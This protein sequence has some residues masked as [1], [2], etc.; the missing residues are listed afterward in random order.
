MISSLRAH[1]ALLPRKGKSDSLNPRQVVILRAWRDTR[2]NVA[3]AK[4]VGTS[5]QNSLASLKSIVHRLR[6][7]TYDE[8]ATKADRLGLL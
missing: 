2:S 8:A 5:R 3:V 7:L 6:V 1:R 4:L